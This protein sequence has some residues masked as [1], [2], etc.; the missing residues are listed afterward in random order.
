MPI[1]TTSG[2]ASEILNGRDFGC[3]S[4]STAGRCPPIFG[5]PDSDSVRGPEGLMPPP[6]LE[7]TRPG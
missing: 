4:L 5:R 1:A 3:D 2:H 7:K 6:G